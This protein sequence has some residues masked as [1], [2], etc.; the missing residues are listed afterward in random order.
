MAITVHNGDT[1]KYAHE[2]TDEE[3]ERISKQFRGI[4]KSEEHKKK[5]SE[6][7]KGK[8]DNTGEHN[9][10][11]GKTHTEGAKKKMSECHKGVRTKG[12]EGMHWYT[13]GTS[14]VLTYNCP[15]G[16]YPGRVR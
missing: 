14:N 11:Y 9:P 6:G 7:N 8:H 12:S 16:F 3:R 4:P 5:I 10:M 13:N 15:E 2:Y 1:A